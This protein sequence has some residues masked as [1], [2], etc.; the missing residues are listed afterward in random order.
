MK[1]KP[2]HCIFAACTDITPGTKDVGDRYERVWFQTTP[3]YGSYPAGGIVTGPDGKPVE[4]A[5]IVFDEASTAAVMESFAAAAKTRGWPGVLVDQEHFSLD[6]DKPSTALAWAKEIR[7]DDD[8][9]LWT[10]WE[11]TEKGLKLWEGRMLVN[12]S[13]VLRLAKAGGS[14]YTPVELQSIGM[15]NTPHFKELSTL[16]AA[17][18]AAESTTNEGEIP[19]DPEILAALGLAEGA[20]KEEVIAAI[21]ALKDKE[22]AAV[23]QATDAEKKAEDAEAA[24]RGLKADA[25]IAA[26]KERIADAAKFREAYLK[27]PEATEAA[28][29]LCK[30][31]PAAKPSETRIVAREAKTPAATVGS[32]DASAKIAARSKAV[33]DYLAAHRNATHAEAWSACRMADPE[34]FTD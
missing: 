23:A 19:M 11:F 4:N 12:R 17:K 20:G 9:S 14:R 5:E 22:A 24:C 18:A 6:A 32:G 3:P 31:A 21:K 13:P 28:F 34:T 25:F 16:A 10:R 29:A 33:N 1:L 30:A 27:A 26:N 15:T 7:R 2:L 8:G